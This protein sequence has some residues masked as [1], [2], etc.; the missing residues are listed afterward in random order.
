MTE[1]IQPENNRTFTTGKGDWAGDLVWHG[2]TFLGHQGYI[3]VICEP[4]PATK[5]ISLKYPAIKPIPTKSNWPDWKVHVIGSTGNGWNLGM[6]LTDG[7]YSYENTVQHF[8]SGP[9]WLGEGVG[10]DLPSDWNINNSELSLTISLISDLSGEI[11]FDD[12][13]LIV[14]LPTKIQYLPLVGVG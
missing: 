10:G 4:T 13:S 3:S 1:R 8:F 2:D 11:A 7:I 9:V 5:T 14:L 6:K 12:F